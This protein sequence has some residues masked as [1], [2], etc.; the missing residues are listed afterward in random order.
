MWVS[1]NAEKEFLRAVSIESPHDPR[2]HDIPLGHTKGVKYTDRVLVAKEKIRRGLASIVDQV[3]KH[4]EVLGEDL[5]SHFLSISVEKILENNETDLVSE[6]LEYYR[7]SM[8]WVLWKCPLKDHVCQLFA[9]STPQDMLLH[10]SDHATACG[11]ALPAMVGDTLIACAYVP[12]DAPHCGLYLTTDDEGR[13]LVCLKKLEYL[14]KGINDVV[15]G[16]KSETNPPDVALANFL[17][18]LSTVE[19]CIC[20]AMLPCF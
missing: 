19:V 15:V 8:S 9:A 7:A 18:H 14:F 1:S 5:K 2:D 6:A 20:L 3:C 12:N 13:E 16:V 17:D 10:V 11:K 4:F